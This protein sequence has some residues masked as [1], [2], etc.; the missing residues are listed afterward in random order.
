[1]S[2]FPKTLRRVLDG[3]DL[4]EAQ[5]R[6]LIGGFMDG[7]VSAVQAAGLLAALA[8]KGESVG[9]LIGAARAMRERSLHVEHNLPLVFDVCGTGG[10]GADTINI[11]TI[12]GFV[13]AAAGVPVAKHG[14]RA[15]SSACGSADVL[16]ASGIEI[17][18]APDRAAAQLCESN[19]TFMFAPRYHPAM[20]AVAPVRRELGVRTMFNILG[21][22]TNPARATH[23]IVGVA[24]ESHLEQVGD[25]LSALGVQGA[26]VHAASGIDE[27]SGEGPTVVYE[28]GTE[29]ARRYT[30][31]P[32][33][34][35][36]AA[37]L[38]VL[39]GG[40]AQTCKD[41]FESILQGERSAR[42]DV[43]ALN[44]ALSLQLSGTAAS[45]SEGLTI[46]RDLLHSGKAYDVVQRV[47]SFRNA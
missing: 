7:E 1:M 22:L 17:D 15:A 43:V 14:N 34:Y 29:R 47:R 36:I 38:A 19:F 23:Q 46:A 27:V 4:D 41:A 39:R 20:K 37:P 42:S 6:E 2:D 8:A 30:L 45:F 10:D 40:S 25:V 5:S 12:A 32:A 33:E 9:E 16:E 24:R 28:F 44:A 18:V 35:G 3:R 11:S 31:D 26:V 13:I 21:P